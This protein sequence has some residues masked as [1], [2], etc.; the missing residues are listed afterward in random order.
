[1]HAPPCF[2]ARPCCPRPP[3][4][5]FSDT[6]PEASS[7]QERQTSLQIQRHALKKPA[8]NTLKH[9]IASSLSFVDFRQR[10]SS[11]SLVSRPQWLNTIT[12]R[13]SAPMPAASL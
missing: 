6:S 12:V 8:A 7:G 11:C 5:L 4:P 2:C 9:H 13:F 3:Q 10:V 1:M